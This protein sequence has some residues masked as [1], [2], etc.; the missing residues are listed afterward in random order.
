MYLIILVWGLSVWGVVAAAG[1][2]SPAGQVAT[3]SIEGSFRD[4]AKVRSGAAGSQRA[5]AWA[6]RW[7]LT[8][9]DLTVVVVVRE[10]AAVSDVLTVEI[11]HVNCDALE[12]RERVDDGALMVARG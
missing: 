7:E 2:D 6:G 3:L 9:A 12:V 1:S 11:E 8:R 5:L 10:L 4:E